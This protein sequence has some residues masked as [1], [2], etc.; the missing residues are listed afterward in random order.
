M[1]WYVGS[2]SGGDTFK[3][4][5]HQRPQT[6]DLITLHHIEVYVGVLLLFKM[7][8]VQKIWREKLFFFHQNFKIDCLTE[9]PN[10]L[11]I[12]PPLTD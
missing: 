5:V 2:V 12:L 7:F 8:R 6:S 4:G 1:L 11:G 9:N 3:E 10:F